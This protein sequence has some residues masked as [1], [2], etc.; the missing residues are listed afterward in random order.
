[1]NALLHVACGQEL[2]GEND[3]V[4]VSATN[5]PVERPQLERAVASADNLEDS[6]YEDRV[7]DHNQDQSSEAFSPL[8]TL[9]E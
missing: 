2:S 9:Y 6:V 1:M 4:V 5:H 8:E 7:I 3:S